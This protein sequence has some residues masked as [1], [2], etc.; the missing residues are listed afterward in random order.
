MCLKKLFFADQKSLCAAAGVIYL[1]LTIA[2]MIFY[3][4]VLRTTFSRGSLINIAINIILILP[5]LPFF[6]GV[7]IQLS[8]LLLPL[9]MS[10]VLAVFNNIVWIIIAFFVDL[11][12]F[13][14]EQDIFKLELLNSV[15]FCLVFS[16]FCVIYFCVLVIIACYFSRVHQLNLLATAD[17]SEKK[18]YPYTRYGK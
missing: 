9:M 13:H 11:K 5:T 3:M 6:V 12:Y 14:P 1:V 10:V 7:Y 18:Y 8:E 2:T 16:I 17:L 4:Y 15:T